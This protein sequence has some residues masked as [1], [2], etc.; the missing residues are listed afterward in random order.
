VTTPPTLASLKD[1]LGGEVDA[2]HDGLLEALL[3]RARAIF[4]QHSGLVID[5]TTAAVKYFTVPPR[6]AQA[7][8]FGQPVE[9]SEVAL[10]EATILGGSYEASLVADYELRGNRYLVRIGSALGAT[11][12][13]GAD[14]VRVTYAAGYDASHPMP[15]DIEHAII[16]AAAAMFRERRSATP[17]IDTGA[18]VQAS[19][20]HLPPGFWSTVQSHRMIHGF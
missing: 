12:P 19:G 7:L 1:Y 17:T 5:R 14:A 6:G 16:E 20:G 3:A 8:W 18:A 15:A 9:V 4:A 13:S 10:R 11:W 2:E